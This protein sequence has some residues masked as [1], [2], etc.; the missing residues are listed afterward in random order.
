MARHRPRVSGH[1]FLD[2]P[3]SLTLGDISFGLSYVRT[4][5]VPSR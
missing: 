1:D 3:H 2:G 4:M 5:A